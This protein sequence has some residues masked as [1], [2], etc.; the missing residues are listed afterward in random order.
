M[1]R[2]A[3]ADYTLDLWAA[4]VLFYELVVG[5]TPFKGETPKGALQTFRPSFSSA[6]SICT[7]GC[8][9]ADH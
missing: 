4:G 1:I 3:T 9:R 6:F 7:A 8:S 5:D 2:E